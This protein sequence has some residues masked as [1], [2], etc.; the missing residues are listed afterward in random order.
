MS[1][2]A[3][4]TSAKVK[5]FLT[6]K[7]FYIKHVFEVVDQADPYFELLVLKFNESGELPKFTSVVKENHIEMDTDIR[8]V[9][10]N[11]CP[12]MESYVGLLSSMLEES[13]ITYEVVKLNTYKEA[14][15]MGSP[16]GTYGLYHKGQLVTHELMSEKKFE[17]KFE[18]F[19]NNI[20][21]DTN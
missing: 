16:F 14:Q 17:K 12:Y 9:Y 1:G 11:Q 10:S 18:K 3:V 8:F 2:I 21:V 5:P 13:G 20:K 6:D 4:V 7:K 19:L 15:E